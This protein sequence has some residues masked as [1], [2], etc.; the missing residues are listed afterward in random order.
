MKFMPAI[1]F[2]LLFFLDAAAQRTIKGRVV[3]DVTGAPISGSSVFISNTSKGTITDNAGQFE[4][5]DITAGKHDLVISCIGYETNVYSFT[6]DQ[7]PLKLKIEM[8]LKVKELENV[9][10]EP[11]VEEGW[12]KWGK[13]FMDYFV[14]TSEN[15]A[16][17]KIK[18]QKAIK[19]RYYKKS[20]RLRSFADE[21]VLLEN[22]A[23][24]YL[25]RYQLE[26]FDLNFRESS[27]LF[28]GYPLFEELKATKR[29]KER[30]SDSREYAYN[31]SIAHFMKS[32]FVDSLL[33]NGF[34]VRRLVCQPNLEKERVKK[35]YK[36]GRTL[37]QN[38][39]GILIVTKDTSSPHSP[40][41]AAYYQQVMR[42]RDI[43]D[44]VGRELLTADSLI[45]K[46]EGDYKVLYFENHLYITYT[47][48]KEELIY[49]R[50]FH[51]SGSAGQLS[52]V[53]LLN[54]AFIT[55]DKMGN[56]YNPKDFSTTAYWAWSERMGTLV[57]VDY[58][59]VKK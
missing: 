58:V 36:P 47:K 30:W 1:L 2:S 55:F 56:Y 29:A 43:N 49:T 51:P 52:Y 6:H 21:P 20:N 54:D 34:E 9:L 45:V 19:F 40:D 50:M 39:G 16:L 24:G 46:S 10:L 32:L 41:S 17:C 42:Q 22:K 27:F 26:E 44:I 48:E 14:G 7:L 15:A 38:I 13:T 5:T 18:N 59:P 12:D 4:L 11:F 53:H 23:L 28:L 33:Q 37:T 25:V 31:G 8:T 57:P 3:N 35:I